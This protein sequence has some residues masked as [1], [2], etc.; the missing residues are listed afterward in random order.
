[1]AYIGR[2]VERES[3]V[4]VQVDWMAR[5]L[6][7]TSLHVALL[8]ARVHRDSHASDEDKATWCP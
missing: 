7:S 6:E 1:M 4:E 8:T 3:G 5:D 2:K